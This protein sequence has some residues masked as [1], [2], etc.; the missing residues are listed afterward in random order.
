MNVNFEMAIQYINM[1]EYDKAIESLKK[2]IADEVEN[3]NEKAATE[4][5]CVLGELLADLGRRD[6]SEAEF[7]KVLDYCV[8]TNSLPKQARIA[9]EFLDFFHGKVQLVSAP[10]PRNRAERRHLNKKSPRSKG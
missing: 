6:E 7:I 9:K 10:V 2:A 3:N 1:E 5:T 4:Y 8:K